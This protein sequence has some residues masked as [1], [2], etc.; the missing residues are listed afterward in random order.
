MKNKTM[1]LLLAF[2]FSL[3]TLFGE[4]FAAHT[5]D[6]H[7][8]ITFPTCT[9]AGQLIYVC[10]CGDS[11]VEKEYPA[12]GHNWNEGVVTTE[13][14]CENTGIK[15]F[16]CL[17]CGAT[18]T[19]ILPTFGGHKWD[20]GSVTTE[21]T[22]GE[23]GER[24]FRCTVCDAT[25]TES[26]APTGKHNFQKGVC[27]VCGE[28]DPCP[29][30]AFTDVGTHGTQEIAYYYHDAID[31]AVTLGITNGTS[32]TTFSPNAGC[33]RAQAVTFIWRAAGEPAPKTT[34]NPFNDVKEDA[35]YYDAVLWAAEQEITNGTSATTF[36]PNAT[37]T[38]AQIVTF[39]WRALQE[40]APTAKECQFK[41]VNQSSYYYNAVL[42]AVEH[43][44]TNGT[45]ATAFSPN[46]T[47]TRAQ[48]VT[49]FYRTA[50]D[51]FED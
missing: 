45:S 22:C 30:H 10:S 25:R 19:E 33:T 12:L 11:Y 17:R 8:E 9:E 48:I 42:W 7:A 23:Y 32:A 1:I 46:A 36:S 18:R 27:T 16:T 24:T 28:K 20:A 21:P 35:Y 4:A 51:L 6:Y 37:C 15:T 43:N 2:V 41:D 50:Q 14:T 31:W 44:V 3:L 26:I 49:F 34:D 38:R 29:S 39:L 47:C 5:H 13:P 40:P